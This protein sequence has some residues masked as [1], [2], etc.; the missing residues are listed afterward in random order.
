[1]RLGNSPMSHLTYLKSDE[2]QI[3]KKR[4]CPFRRRGIACSVWR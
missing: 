1:M 2:S 4:Q 3:T